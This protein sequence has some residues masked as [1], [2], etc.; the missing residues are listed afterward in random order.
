PTTL[1]NSGI[2]NFA[3]GHSNTADAED[4]TV[5]E[6][7]LEVLKT[8]EVGGDGDAD[9]DAGDSVTYTIII[10][11]TG[12]SET[13]AFD[14][15][16]ADHIPDEITG[17]SM[18]VVDENNDD[19]TADFDLSGNDVSMGAPIDMPE[20]RT[21]TITVTGTLAAD[22][23]PSQ[24]ISNTASVQWQSLDDTHNQNGSVN[25]R[26][27]AG[28]DNNYSDSD[29]ADITITSVTV[30]KSLVDTEISDD[31]QNPD[32]ID[33]AGVNERLEVII[34]EEATYEVV[35]TMPEGNM[36]GATLVDDLDAGLAIQRIDV[37]TPTG[38][39]ASTIALDNVT[40]TT[41]MIGGHQRVTFALGDLT[42][43]DDNGGAET[44]TLRYTVLVL[45]DD[46]NNSGDTLN[47]SAQFNFTGGSSNVDSAEDITVIEP[48]ISTVKTINGVA[49]PGESSVEVGDVVKYTVVLT[50]TGNAAAYEVTALDTLAP[51]TSYF[52]D[53]THL[54]SASAGGIGITDNGDGTILITSGADGW[55]LA[56]GA[57][58]TI[59][60]FAQ[61]GAA[62]FDSTYGTTAANLVN[63]VDADWSSNDDTTSLT[64]SG[65][66]RI[67]DDG[68]NGH[69]YTVDGTQDDDP[70]VFN[71]NYDGSI[72]DTV[73]FDADHSGDL[74]AGDTG[75]TNLGVTLTADV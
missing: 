26:T 35:I 11:H 19:V 48:V 75:I 62:Y 17:L 69:H 52:T 3:G 50:N 31:A 39:L 64:S 41:E 12:D 70:A 56:E 71:I 7:D 73:F 22:V 13:D 49:E 9:G 18:S 20:T 21:F 74:S 72:G 30:A 51:G 25:E 53:G 66:D 68:A 32:L 8:V 14:V 23:V 15:T 1:D 43:G 44:L 57:S 33:E 10:Q 2:L 16:F 58:V 60:Y 67:Y 47:N 29:S 63:S 5:I 42:N 59:T 27:G 28:G 65:L 4:I 34:G 38:D 24:S 46:G 45:N 6:P 40:Y 54:P 55:D 37:V 36:D 61:V